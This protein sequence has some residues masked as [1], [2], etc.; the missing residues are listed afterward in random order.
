[1]VNPISSNAIQRA[2]EQIHQQLPP[3]VQDASAEDQAMFDQLLHQVQE[4]NQQHDPNPTNSVDHIDGTSEVSGTETHSDA[5]NLIHDLISATRKI[6]SDMQD[7]SEQ[8]SNLDIK[9][10]NHDKA[11]AIVDKAQ[12]MSFELKAAAKIADKIDTDIQTLM[13]RSN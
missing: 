3:M 7:V 13:N 4:A 6:S 10:L 2:S 9:D 1:M 11:Q 5:K 8:F 12:M